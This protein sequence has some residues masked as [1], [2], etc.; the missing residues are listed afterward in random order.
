M[1]AFVVVTAVDGTDFIS[2]HL[3][4][5]IHILDGECVAVNVLL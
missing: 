3:L 4:H 1:T 2:A 5:R